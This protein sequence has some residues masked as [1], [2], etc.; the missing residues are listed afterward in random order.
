[1]PHEGTLCPVH[2]TPMRLEWG[3]TT[4]WYCG[5][6]A[7]HHPACTDTKY[8]KMCIKLKNHDGRHRAE[9]GDEWS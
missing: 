6:C 5:A 2:E 7:K 3:E 4:T 8:M 9:N 1:M